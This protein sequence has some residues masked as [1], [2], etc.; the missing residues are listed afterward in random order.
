M[1]N[2]NNI[3]ELQDLRGEKTLASYITGLVLCLILT[4][5]PFVL[6]GKALLPAKELYI[7]LPILAVAQLFIQSAFFLRLNASPTGRWTLMAFLF[8]ILVVLVLVIGS[9]WIM[10]NLNYNMVHIK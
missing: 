4:I 5:I 9:L 2:D 1:S 7:I 6:V 8:A 10:Y 3:V